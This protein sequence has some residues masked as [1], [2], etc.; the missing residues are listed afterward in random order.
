MPSYV[1]RC[2]VMRT[3]HVMQARG[4][5]RRG[6]RV[7]AR[8]PRGLEAGEVLTVAD[9]RVVGQLDSPPSGTIQR[10]MSA[11]D[12]S[13]LAR[14]TVQIAEDSDRCLEIIQELDLPMDLVDVERIFGGERMVIY[15][16][17]ETRVDFRDLVKRLAQQFQTRVEMRQIGVRDEA[18]LL[19]D[20]GDCGK[21]VCCNTHLS[22]MPPVSMKMAKLQKATLDPN[23]ISGRCGR[24]KCCLRYEYDT[25]E[26]HRKSMP[27]IGVDIITANGRGRV[28]NQELLSRQ[29]LV[30]MEDDRRV[31]IHADDVL[32]VLKRKVSSARRDTL[33]P[34]ASGPTEDGTPPVQDSSERVVVN[35]TKKRER[36]DNG[37]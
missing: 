8:T 15:Y 17:S 25:Y 19:A 37:E 23:K 13:E 3:L 4:E 14:L 2:G 6:M 29:L 7:I 10:E 30:L 32:S 26:E 1:V 18:K 22:K 5:F 27:K 16:L 36:T 33:P 21:P 11:E 20:Y 9:E 35:D 28:L 24:L 34:P 31:M 12:E